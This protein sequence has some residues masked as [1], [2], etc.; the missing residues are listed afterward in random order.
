MTK[1]LKVL[2]VLLSTLTGWGVGKVFPVKGVW[3]SPSEEGNTIDVIEV[4]F[5]GPLE[6]AL[7]GLALG[8]FIIFVLQYFSNEQDKEIERRRDE[9]IDDLS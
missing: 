8:L 3:L 2:V 4:V 6:G 7:S 5:F 9:V 1:F